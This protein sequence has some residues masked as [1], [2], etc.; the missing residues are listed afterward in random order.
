MWSNLLSQG[1]MHLNPMGFNAAYSAFGAE[2]VSVAEVGGILEQIF[3]RHG[4]SPAEWLQSQ[5]VD[6]I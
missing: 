2:Y 1:E 3:S 6:L 4:L 5:T